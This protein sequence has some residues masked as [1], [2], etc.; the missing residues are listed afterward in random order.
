MSESRRSFLRKIA[1]G[2]GLSSGGVG[3]FVRSLYA[4][5]T[6][7][8]AEG[9]LAEENASPTDQSSSNT[10]WQIGRFNDSSGEFNCGVDPVT[11]RLTID[12]TDPSRDPVYIPGKSDPSKQWYAFQPGTRNR[13]AGYRP[14]PYTIEFS[15]PDVP[16]GLYTLKVAVL[17]EH[18]SVSRLQVEI[19]GHVGRFHFHPKLN[20]AM[21]DRANCDSPEYSSDTITI[22]LPTHLLKKGANKLVLTAVDE[23]DAQD[24]RGE[25]PRGLNSGLVYDALSLD[26]DPS[27]EFEE[28]K[29]NVLAVPTVFY[30][31]Q[32]GRLHEL[33]DVF[34]R[35]NQ[36]VPAGELTLTLGE[37]KSTQHFGSERAFGEYRIEFPVPEFTSP[38]QGEVSVVANALSKHVPVDLTPAKKWNLFVVPH[39]HLDMGFTDYQSK[40]AEVQCRNIDE[41]LDILQTRP[42]FRLSLD[43][44]WI[45]EQFLRTRSEEQRQR[46]A[47]AVRENKI[48]MPAQYMNLL[49]GF[50]TR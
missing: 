23:G 43:G 28:T 36:P 37:W 27:R 6:W 24:P 1:T 2:T 32:E 9:T 12:Y 25:S 39:V 46:F 11:D 8:L 42:D 19:E 41:A 21:G 10:L 34:V 48:C 50:P 5:P 13:E 14:H 49:T 4:S 7:A 18:P 40:I 45:V 26:H 44:E 3:I 38:T 35:V 33:I 16:K 22:E 31:M 20:Y 17:V 15:L 30:K 29:V 47:T